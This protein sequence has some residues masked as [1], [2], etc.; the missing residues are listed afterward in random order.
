MCERIIIINQGQIVADGTT[1]ELSH[2]LSDENRLVAR[3]AGPEPDVRVLLTELP[4]VSRVIS[5]GGREPES[6]DWQ[7]E[8]LHGQDIRRPLFAAL[9]QSGWPLLSLDSGEMTLE[10]IFLRMTSG[11]EVPAISDKDK[12][13]KKKKKDARKAGEAPAEAAAVPAEKTPEQTAQET[14]AEQAGAPDTQTDAAQ[15]PE[16]DA[17]AAE[18]AEHTEGKD[19]QA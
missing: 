7:V 13:K 18:T 15:P 8:T 16:T 19:G 12:K 3:I 17:P 6:C 14:P 9:A 10:D 1:A 11:E 2:Q 5:L 4:G